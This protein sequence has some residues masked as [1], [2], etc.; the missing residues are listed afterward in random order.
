MS[1]LKELV[2]TPFKKA[3]LIVQLIS[4]ILI[5]GSP[6]IGGAISTIFELSKKQTGGLILVIFIVGEAL[7]YFSLFFLGKEVVKLLRMNIMKRFKKKK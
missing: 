6:L 3:M 4:Y 7:F 5:P 1:Q 2:N